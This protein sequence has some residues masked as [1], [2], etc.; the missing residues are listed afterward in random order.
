LFDLI[1]VEWLFSWPSLGFLGYYIGGCAWLGSR[2]SWLNQ[3]DV[4][5]TPRAGIWHANV[6]VFYYRVK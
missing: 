5:R 1:L 6:L 3:A 4:A 2:T